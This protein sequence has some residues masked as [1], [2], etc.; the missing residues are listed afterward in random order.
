MGMHNL[1]IFDNTLYHLEEVENT[2]IEY[3]K[4][5]EQ[6]P[7]PQYQAFLT[8]LE[9]QELMST[10]IMEKENS[11]LIRLYQSLQRENPI[12]YLCQMFLGEITLEQ[13]D[14]LHTI[15]IYG[16]DA[17]KEENARY[18]NGDFLSDYEKWVGYYQYG[19]K[20][21][22]YIPPDPKEVIKY[23]ENIVHFMNNSKERSL[24]YN[25]FIKSF[26]VHLELAALQPF[27]DGNTRTARLLQSG[28][29]WKDS[30][31]LLNKN[32]NR[33]ILYASCRYKLYAGTYRKNIQ[34]IVVEK[35]NDA[36]NRWFEFNLN[37]FDEFFY[38]SNNDL[39]YLIKRK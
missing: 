21:V 1:K 15:L 32:M 5:L 18:R 39:D 13:I 7:I 36:W 30:K 37:M 12:D 9:S 25:T 34:S 2:Y 29:I 23:M 33:P 8:T 10:Q 19:N 38:K 17:D 14:H 27:G 26:I 6:L 4:K 20:V 24:L 35:S 22:Q 31:E 3:I 16:T 11:F 28:S